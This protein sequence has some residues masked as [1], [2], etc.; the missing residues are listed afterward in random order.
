MCEKQVHLQ[1][2]IVHLWRKNKN[3]EDMELLNW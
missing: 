1:D 2:E 3:E